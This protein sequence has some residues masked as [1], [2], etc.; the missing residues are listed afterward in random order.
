M[1]YTMTSPVSSGPPDVVQQVGSTDGQLTVEPL[2]V[3]TGAQIRG[4]D[5]SGELDDAVVAQIREALL[6]HKV[7]FLR[8]QR[9]DYDRLV[10]F[11]KRFGELTLG[12]PVYGGPEGRPLLREMD[13]KG[14]GTRANHWHA[15][16][17]Y[18]ADPPAIAILHNTVCPPVGGDT[19]WAN[20]AAAYN[21]LPEGLRALADELRVIHSNDSDFT[22]ATYTGTA[23]VGYLK[24]VFASEHPAVRVHP[25]T[26]ERSLLL[27]GFARSVPEHS[28]QA[29]R[30]LIRILQEYVVRP[31]YSVRWRWQVGDLVMW[32]NRSTLH[33]AVHDY[34]DQHRR[35]ERVTVAGTTTV[36][37][38][39]RPGCMV[40]GDASAFSAGM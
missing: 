27:G 9:L 22:Q 10:A 13:S 17:T 31:E 39:G 28:P 14:E 21:E 6:R 40:Q 34:G 38:D 23:R 15:D 11:G 8:G 32:D 7:V 29:G 12:H 30:D 4:V 36:G 5:A 24:N 1:N 25:E 35:G 19:I 16:F 3:S 18:L 2:T 26:G 20:T 37:V 33:Y